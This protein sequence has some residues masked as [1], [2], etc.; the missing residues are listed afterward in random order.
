MSGGDTSQI[1][2]AKGSFDKVQDSVDGVLKQYP[3]YESLFD[4]LENSLDKPAMLAQEFDKAL[5]DD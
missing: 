1:D 4:E 3:E 2:K 5:K